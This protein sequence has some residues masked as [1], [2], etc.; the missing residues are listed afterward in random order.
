MPSNLIFSR[1]GKEQILLHTKNNTNDKKMQKFFFL[2]YNKYIFY[3][4]R[5]KTHKYNKCFFL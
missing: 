4:Y 3:E 2:K 5:N 1:K